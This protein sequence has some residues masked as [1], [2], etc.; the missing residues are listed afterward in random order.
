MTFHTSV[1]SLPIEL[2]GR[3]L[4]SL[5]PNQYT[6]VEMPPG[7]H[8]IEVPNTAWSRAISGI[9][10]PADV[11]VEAG[12]VYYLLPKRW[13][14]ESRTTLTMINNMAIPAQTAAAHSSFSV[15]V[16]SPAAAPPSDFLHLTLA[17][18]QQ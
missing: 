8:V 15:Q 18:A 2:D 4:V 10:H 5:G 11:T 6:R 12:K 9:P 3:P 16:S 17:D 14:G 7:R 1:F 13:A